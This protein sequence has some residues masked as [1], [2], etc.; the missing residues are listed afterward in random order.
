VTS[1]RSCLPAALAYAA[2][3]WAV[4]P[5]TGVTGG[6]CGCGAADCSSPGKHPLTRHGLKEASTDAGVVGAWW[7]RW[8]RANVAVA[9]GSAS[10]LIVI[11]VDLPGGESSL[12]RLADE[13]YPLPETVTARTGSGGIHLYYAAPPGALGNAA[14]RLPRIGF[15]LP[16]V[17]LRAEGG[18]VVAPPSLHVSGSRYE[19]VDD[20]IMLAPAPPW[21]RAP[22]PKPSIRPGAHASRAAGSTRYGLAALDDELERLRRAPVG[23]RNQTLNRA[24][25]CLA[26]LVAGG[27]LR[28]TEV[29]D[30]LGAVAVSRGL[31]RREA[32]RTVASGLAAGRLHP[33]RS[34]SQ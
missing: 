1:E 3:G 24:A 28:E 9:T 6:R 22:E 11:D 32:E 5:V 8:P 25:F 30:A 18:Y 26:Q 27:E 14:G 10:G 34:S 21:L 16:G 2:D 7:Q 23:T 12:Y 29:V 33:R 19:W 4:F 31:S 15:E 20:D 17:D 13:G